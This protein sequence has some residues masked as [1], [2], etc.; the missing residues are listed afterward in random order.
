MDFSDLAG[1]DEA[2]GGLLRTLDGMAADDEVLAAL[3]NEL[4]HLRR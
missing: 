2:I 4:A 3:S 1:R